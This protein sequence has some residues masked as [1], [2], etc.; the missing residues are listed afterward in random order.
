MAGRPEIADFSADS[1]MVFTVV[2]KATRTQVTRSFFTTNVDQQ[3]IISRREELQ[4]ISKCIDT[5]KTDRD[6]VD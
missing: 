4:N 2:I 5:R 6:I 1:L 3:K